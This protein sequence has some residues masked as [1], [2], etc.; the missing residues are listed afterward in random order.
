[1]VETEVEAATT[2]KIKPTQD[3]EIDRD[4]LDSIPIDRFEQKGRI[5][6]T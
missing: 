5:I 4:S 2:T 6:I 3:K 1:M